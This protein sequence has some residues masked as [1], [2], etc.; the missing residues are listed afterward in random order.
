[1]SENK[2]LDEPIYYKESIKRSEN[3]LKVSIVVIR[4]IQPN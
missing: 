3:G 2:Y 4:H 1:M